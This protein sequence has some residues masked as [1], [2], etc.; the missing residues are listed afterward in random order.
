MAFSYDTTIDP[1][2]I[3]AATSPTTSNGPFEHIFTF[4]WNLPDRNMNCSPSERSDSDMSGSFSDSAH[5]TPYLGNNRSLPHGP[6]SFDLLSVSSP[7][8][9]ADAAFREAIRFG[10]GEHGDEKLQELQL[11]PFSFPELDDSDIMDVSDWPYHEAGSNATALHVDSHLDSRPSPHHSL[12][13]SASCS[14]FFPPQHI[15]PAALTLI[16]PGIFPSYS[17]SSQDIWQP[18]LTNQN[19]VQSCPSSASSSSEYF[20]F[21]FQSDPGSSFPRSGLPEP[22]STFD[23]P[24]SSARRASGHLFHSPTLPL[25]LAPHGLGL[26]PNCPLQQLSTPSLSYLDSQPSPSF[27][28]IQKVPLRH[29]QPV[30]PIPLIR[31]PASTW[32]QESAPVSSTRDSRSDL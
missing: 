17:D 19:D 15:N 31:I 30:R 16:G 21:D 22:P 26:E 5:S 6:P 32:E 29:P 7:M 20:D 14:N 24:L 27:V 1:S 11:S 2:C 12:D 10:T 18:R 8:A 3:N 25:P 13:S 23:S 9:I 28:Q 4:K